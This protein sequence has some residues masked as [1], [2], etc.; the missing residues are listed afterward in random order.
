[1]VIRVIVVIGL[2]FPLIAI[3]LMVLATYA[4]FLV[5]PVYAHV[6]AKRRFG[7]VRRYGLAGALRRLLFRRSAPARVVAAVRRAG[8]L[9]VVPWGGFTVGAALP[10][11]LSFAFPSDARQIQGA[12]LRTALIAGAVGACIAVVVWIRSLGYVARPDLPRQGK[13]PRLIFPPGTSPEGRVRIALNAFGYAQ[14]G[15]L[16]VLGFLYPWLL[17]FALYASVPEAQAARQGE[18]P[19][20]SISLL[21]GIGYLA[22]FCVPT[23]LAVR[24]TAGVLRRRHAV[25]AAAVAIAEFLGPPP[26]PK[27]SDAA[28]R[29]A[30][31]VPD[32]LPHTRDRLVRVA[33]Q[34]TEAAR[35][36]DARQ[37]RG[38]TPH[39]LATVLRGS[40]NRVQGF[41]ASDRALAPAPPDDLVGVLTLTFQLLAGSAGPETRA[42]LAGLVAAFDE[43][44]A[45]AVTLHAR[46][47]G[48]LA[49]VLSRASTGVERAVLLLG[50][51][52]TIVGLVLAVV[53]SARGSGDP[54]DLVGHLIR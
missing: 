18:T 36:L 21:V 31:R 14:V 52:A 17:L 7:L 10:I 13:L 43:D 51:T 29:L 53:L 34:L 4:S 24:A 28:D 46:P 47:P 37:R 41:L 54:N 1:M 23:A 12:L 48:R 20:Q 33:E 26:R 3:W 38:F 6:L 32:P 2:I 42:E 25:S 35:Q 9:Y 5:R 27:P 40:A 15:R 45:P 19:G 22:L 49:T 39:P 30:D 11:T 8:P 50:G 16:A 44:G